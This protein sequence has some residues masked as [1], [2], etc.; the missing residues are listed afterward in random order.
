MTA[1]VVAFL[2]LVAGALFMQILH[3]TTGALTIAGGLILLILALK[4]RPES[5]RKTGAGRRARR[6]RTL[7]SMAIYP[8]GI[9]LLLNPVGI[10][11]L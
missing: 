3:F 5:R 8:L 2:L 9:P 1:T 6:E 7:M 10:V 11:A 4:H